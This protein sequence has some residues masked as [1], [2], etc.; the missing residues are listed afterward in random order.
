MKPQDPFQRSFDAALL[1]LLWSL[2]ALAFLAGLHFAVLTV[3]DLLS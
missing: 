1:L 3:A 2:A